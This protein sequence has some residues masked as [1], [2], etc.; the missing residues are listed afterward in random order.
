MATC[1]LTIFNAF[2]GVPLAPNPGPGFFERG[3]AWISIRQIAQCALDCTR[4]RRI[5]RIAHM[6]TDRQKQDRWTDT[7]M[8]TQHCKKM[9]RQ[10]SLPASER[11]ME[12]REKGREKDQRR[13]EIREDE[14]PDK[15]SD[16]TRV[17]KRETRQRGETR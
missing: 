14:R 10:I 8:E 1:G 4:M 12:M 9:N 15:M 3:G 6:Q 13:R 16:Q 5:V 7:P 11:R 17:Y 2:G